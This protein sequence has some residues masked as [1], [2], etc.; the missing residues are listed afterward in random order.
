MLPL[1]TRA[2]RACQCRCSS[3]AAFSSASVGHGRRLSSRS[4]GTSKCMPAEKDDGGGEKARHMETVVREAAQRFRGTLP[5][6]Y[7]S[8]QEYALYKRLYGPP[9]RETEPEDVGIPTHADLGSWEEV[10]GDEAE[11]DAHSSLDP[12]EEEEEQADDDVSSTTSTDVARQNMEAIEQTA[13]GYVNAVARNEREHKALLRLAEDFKATRRELHRKIEEQSALQKEVAKKEEAELALLQGL[14]EDLEEN[15]DEDLKDRLDDRL[16][17]P[18]QE[19]KATDGAPDGAPDGTPAKKGRKVRVIQKSRKA[20]LRLEREAEDEHEDPP[21]RYHPWTLLG[22]F[23][24]RP[25]ALTIPPKDLDGPVRQLLSRT[26]ID[27]VKK[28]ADLIYRDKSFA[29]SPAT[30]PGSKSSPMEGVA[31]PPDQRSMSSIEADAFLAVFMPPAYASILRILSEVRKRIGTEWL[32]SRLKQGARGQLSILDAGAGGAALVAWDQIVKAEWG[33]LKEK[34]KVRRGDEPPPSKKA[35]IVGSSRLRERVV[36]FLPDATLL[37][38]LPDYLHSGQTKGE[39]LEAGDQQQQQKQYDIVV[40]SHLFLKEDAG[41]RRQTLLNKLWTLVSSNGG[42][43]VILEKGH[44]RGFEAMAHARDVILNQFLLPQ[45]GF[46]L[47]DVRNGVNDDEV[48]YGSTDDAKTPMG[49][50]REP[51]YVIAPC[52]NQGTCPMYEASG[53][54]QGRKDYCHFDQKFLAPPY[55]R[56]VTAVKGSGNNQ[57][58]VE[59]S[60]VAIRR[61]VDRGK[62]LGGLQETRNAFDGYFDTEGG[63]PDM[64]MLPRQINR[65][66]KKKHHVI[67]DMCTPEGKLERWTV[68]KSYDPLTYHDARK[69]RWGDLWA[70]GAKTRI[71]RRVRDGEI[72]TTKKMREKF[73]KQLRTQLSGKKSHNRQVVESSEKREKQEDSVDSSESSAGLT[74]RKLTKTQ[75]KLLGKEKRR[76][77]KEMKRQALRDKK[78]KAMATRGE[79]KDDEDDE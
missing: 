64:Q 28:A 56:S 13:D 78:R 41:H 18:K 67:M 57:G 35:A 32:Q 34:G 63:P 19:A 11:S 30:I 45:S 36:T 59:F 61:G 20:L 46:P 74:K 23:H 22:R 47:M 24:D 58:R 25:M 29:N 52:S 26:H 12:K 43:L 70:L 66:L 16:S 4:F 72:E 44:P 27:H 2:R 51:G 6:G 17:N 39:H 7:L 65:P 79:G 5:K 14:E 31:L 53:L 33:V 48:M 76:V 60:Y 10:K 40:A 3:L 54:G 37:T 9:Q 77:K 71:R 55:Y 69:S 62:K 50:E 68:P 49:G 42:I 38:R 73:R 15:P 21:D 8:D 75:K 1:A